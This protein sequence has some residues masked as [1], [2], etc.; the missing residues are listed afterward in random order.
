MLPLTVIAIFIT[1]TALAYAEAIKAD[2]RLSVRTAQARLGDYE[3]PTVKR[4][5]DLKDPFAERVA[6]PRRGVGGRRC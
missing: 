1:A 6:R 3:S 2:A 5:E 4:E